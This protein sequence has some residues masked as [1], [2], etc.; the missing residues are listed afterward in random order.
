M[1]G[2]S[3]ALIVL[4]FSGIYLIFFGGSGIIR[5][6][7]PAFKMDAET[8]LRIGWAFLIAG[9][10]FLLSVIAYLINERF[11]VYFLCP[12]AIFAGLGMAMVQNNALRRLRNRG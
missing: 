2:Y 5:K 10:F 8:S 1:F 12:G 4:A 6:E 11:L 3:E 7:P 9:I